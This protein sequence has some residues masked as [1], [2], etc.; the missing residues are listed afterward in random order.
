MAGKK[1]GKEEEPGGDG[2]MNR[3]LLFCV[4]GL[5]RWR[6]FGA[7]ADDGGGS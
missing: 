7:D 1:V 6:I 3:V 5:V 4:R 2:G